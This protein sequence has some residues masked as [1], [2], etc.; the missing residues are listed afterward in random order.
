MFLERHPLGIQPI[1]ES[2]ETAA[3]QTT[4]YWRLKLPTMA[5]SSHNAF[6]RSPNP[7][8]RSYDSSS[9][10]SATSP[11]PPPQYL[12]S[13]MSTSA[14]TGGA[15]APQSIGIPP[16]PSVSQSAFQPYTPGTASSVMGR[17]SLPSNDSVASTPGLSN[18]QLSANVQAQKRAYRQRRKDPSC[19]ACRER[20]VKCD[21]T[22][23]TSCSECSS[24]NV[25]CQF[26]KETNRRM[27]SIKQVQDLEKQIERVRR[28]NN[29][30]KR[31]LNDRD[32]QM[33]L[34]VESVDQ[35]V[36]T[37]PEIGSEPKRR[38]RAAPLHDPSRARTNVRNISKGLFKPP[39][40]Y[41]Q[42]PLAAPPEVRLPSPPP[43]SVTEALLHSYYGAIHVMM[44]LLHWPTLQREVDEIYQG[45]GL[46]RMS[47]SWLS[48]FFAILAGGSLFSNERHL[49][50]VHQ[51][52][53]LLEISRSLVDPWNNDFSLDNVRTAL[54]TSLVLNELNLKSAAWSGLG[55]AVKMAQDM[56]LH[57]E[58]GA[59]SRLEADMRRR[60][61]WSIY[62][63]DRTM[64]LEMGRPS[65]IHDTDCDVTLPEAI[66]DHFLHAEGPVHPLNADSLTHSLHVIL[67]VVR[68]IPAIM[69]A[70]SS[71]PIT[72]T[73][74]SSFD[75]HFVNCQR[76]F[77]AACDP[78]NPLPIPPHM[79][80]PMAYLMSTRLLLH[81]S[82]L[83]PSCPP[84]IR[85]NAIAQ[86]S[87]TAAETAK[88][89]ARTNATL[90]D[91][92]TALL[93]THIFRSALFLVITEQ[94]EL[95]GVCIRALKS[96][97]VRRDVAVPCGRF[98]SLFLSAVASKRAEVAAYLPRPV[99]GF[100]SQRPPAAAFQDALC[101][102]E[103]L[104]AYLSA[105]LQGG[106]ESAWVW[107]GAERD[108]MPAAALASGGLVR[109]ENRT[110]LGAEDMRDWVGW[111]RLDGQLRGL[112]TESWSP[113]S[114]YAPH[115][116]PPIK[117]E[118]TPGPSIPR[119]S[120]PPNEGSSASPAPS[121]AKRNTE[122]ISIANII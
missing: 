51:A 95:A 54:L 100:G 21:A 71:L 19:D 106:V 114:Q 76:A 120:M 60:V 30:L 70:R 8:T 32:G 79:L 31:L 91:T 99:P 56:S 75:A 22:E 94:H 16:L 52:A 50:R 62:I 2:L 49:D 18:A 97:D 121:A 26:T 98:L 6:P 11:K 112:A 44:P 24:R 105:D 90:A 63:L 27:S 84:D 65:L 102:D 1:G 122:R 64:S 92:A 43:R 117:M 108:A 35:L 28:E 53:E 80:M 86:C 119:N 9:V 77:P 73:R 47:A 5:T 107:V 72:P 34:D 25:K 23:T 103:E 113:T 81:R 66:D 10:S 115:T 59:P 41:R 83:A 42:T 88:L 82:N 38:K 111:D 101:R 13:L 67:N 12:S 57:L 96:I 87:Y 69:Q 15:H 89:I 7:S 48:S 20:K 93:T 17:D 110:G 37:I 46:Q 116:L 14:R 4:A 58:V 104:L 55:T 85:S 36:I 78:E 109:S 61:W 33:D 40:P 29:T 39:A 68:S 118:P 45:A 74:L 3:N